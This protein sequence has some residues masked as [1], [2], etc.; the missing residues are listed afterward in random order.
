MEFVLTALQV[1][2]SSEILCP[3]SS[4]SE[5]EN[6]VHISKIAFA[7][8]LIVLGSSRAETIEVPADYS[9]IQEALDNSLSGDSVL[10]APG[11][12]AENVIWPDVPDIVL[13][14]ELGPDQTI[15]DGDSS[16]TVVSL[17]SALIDS[18]TVITGFTLRN[19][20]AEQGGGILC[21]LSSPRISGNVIED[22]FAVSDGGGIYCIN[23]S[24]I[25]EANTIQ[26]N[27]TGVPLAIGKD[28]TT[29]GGIR[30]AGTGSGYALVTGNIITGNYCTYYGGGIACSRN[31][32][33]E[34]N[35]II[36]NFSDWFGGGV[37]HLNATGTVLENNLISGNTSNWGG[38]IMLQGGHL[39]VSSCEVINNTGDGM[40]IYYGTL[41]A[42]SSA[43][44]NNTGD[45]I[46]CGSG[47]K[48]CSRGGIS[49]LLQLPR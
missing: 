43:F 28:I 39:T 4:V 9:T 18:S 22:C 41:S 14:S 23:S 34:N 29:G 8:V 3:N 36:E 16:G 31:T 6:I 47:G 7:A 26:N 49:A 21:S 2:Y 27:T 37:Y 42:D 30:I 48:S 44:M 12:Y 46:G 15:I 17:L 19:G 25:I 33:I 20:S 45:G 13:T 40:H 5:L 38:G 11:M 24:V 32:L 1:V 10:V 35:Q